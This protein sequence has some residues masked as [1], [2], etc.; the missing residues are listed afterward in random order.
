M[1]FARRVDHRRGGGAGR[2]C[3]DFLSA[4]SRAKPYGHWRGCVQI[5]IEDERVSPR[6]LQCSGGITQRVRSLDTAIGAHNAERACIYLRLE[7]VEMQDV[8]GLSLEMKDPLTRWR[9]RH[10]LLRS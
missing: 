6:P 1:P 9:E 7:H 3:E 5:S 2:V 10:C 8:P 4:Q